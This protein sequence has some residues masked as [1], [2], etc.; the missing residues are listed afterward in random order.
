M[1]CCQ[2]DPRPSPLTSGSGAAPCCAIV[3]VVPEIVTRPSRPAGVGFGASETTTAPE[4][5]PAWPLVTSTND[6]RLPA[7][8]GQFAG[9]LTEIA[10]DPDCHPTSTRVGS[11]V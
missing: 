1:R 8:Q 11:T 10:L 3:M 4:P 6:E 7:F 5:D 9:A 2:K